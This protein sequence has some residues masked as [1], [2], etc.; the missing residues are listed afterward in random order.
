MKQQNNLQK[1]IY[2]NVIISLFAVL[3]LMPIMLSAK[4]DT[5]VT[6]YPKEFY[7]TI[8]TIATNKTQSQQAFILDILKASLPAMIAFIATILTIV[9][10]Y[11]QTKK[12][13][14]HSENITLNKQRTEHIYSL[15][16]MLSK[17]LS[18]FDIN[19]AE[20]INKIK[21]GESISSEQLVL[22][23]SLKIIL[24]SD[25]N[26]GIEFIALIEKYRDKQVN[27]VKAWIDELIL[28]SNKLITN[29]ISK[30]EIK[31]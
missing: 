13:L 28:S 2:L 10:T 21:Q 27:G 24:S 11:K 7:D 8:N 3:L 29:K 15:I 26:G 14:S 16:D 5:L 19:N 22:E 4:T 18:Y 30:N 31:L 20:T 25:A 23:N 6:K 9:F 1:N 12:Q 17:Y